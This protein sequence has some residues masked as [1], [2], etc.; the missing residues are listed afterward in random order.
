MLVMTLLVAVIAFI[1]PASAYS[2]TIDESD[3]TLKPE[4]RRRAPRNNPPAQ[5][6]YGRPAPA[7]APN[8]GYDPRTPF[9]EAAQ[10]QYQPVQNPVTQQQY[11]PVVNPVTQQQYQPEQ[12]P[13][14]PQQYVQ[15]EQQYQQP[16][17]QM[18]PQ[19]Y[20]PQQYQPEPQ[21]PFD[22]QYYQP[23]PVPDMYGQNPYPQQPADPMA[24]LN[25]NGPENGGV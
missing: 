13:V 4:P 8:M 25:D 6:P 20:A 2:S 1:Y 19:Q 23:A 3:P 21:V 5:N 16:P 10:P 17:V 11:E 12:A 9:G 15:P 18:Q 22:Q 24:F 14:A 7:P